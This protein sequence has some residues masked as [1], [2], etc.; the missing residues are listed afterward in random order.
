MTAHKTLKPSRNFLNVIIECVTRILTFHVLSH[1]LC[2][3]KKAQNVS[4]RADL[5]P[6]LTQSA[7]PVNQNWVELGTKNADLK[8]LH[9]ETGGQGQ[10]WSAAFSMNSGASGGERGPCNDSLNLGGGMDGAW[11]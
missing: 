6:I 11:C 2:P 4:T 8:N 9:G 7:R 10:R 5:K 3:R 1:L